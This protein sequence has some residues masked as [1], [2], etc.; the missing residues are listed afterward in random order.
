MNKTF[1]TTKLIPLIT[2]TLCVILYL[3]G[4]FQM[5]FAAILMLIA[6]AIEYK[7]NLFKSLGFQRSRI[8]VKSLL[9]EAPVFGIGFFLFYYYVM[10]PITNNLTGQPIDYSFFE[11]YVGNLPA[12]LGLL[13]FVWISAAF[14]EEIVFRGYLM[15]QFTKFFGSSKISLVINILLL[16]ILFSYMHVYQGISGQVV[17]GITG[18]LF[19]LIFHIRKND[20]W[21][22]IAAHG[23]FDTAAL[24]F[25]Y[26][27]WG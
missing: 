3:S 18:A 12:M 11:P 5:I 17:S 19:A 23:F 26:Y 20:L 22:C 16:G 1:F 2:I 9:I 24:V 4:Y 8:N 13:V 10:V 7:K 15:Q 21:F 25:V 14:G 27:G 6:S